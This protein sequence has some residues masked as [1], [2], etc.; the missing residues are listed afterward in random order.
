M[1][2]AEIMLWVLPASVALMVTPAI[3]VRQLIAAPTPV[4]M[5][6]S[7]SSSRR[8]VLASSLTAVLAPL[9][10]SAG[11]AEDESELLTE[12]RKIKSI[13]DAIRNEQKLELEERARIKSATQDYEQAA[14][15]G[16][17][18]KAAGLKGKV[19]ALQAQLDEEV[20]QVAHE[21]Q[22]GA[23]ASCSRRVS[24]M[25]Q[26]KVLARLQEEEKALVDTE[27]KQ[28]AKVQLEQ[29]SELARE[30]KE[31]SEASM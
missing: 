25:L 5:S 21:P 28:F 12:D 3:S 2:I 18:E 9:V 14:D 29:R 11:L 17:S 22:A 19:A 6:V 31:A 7:G 15:A 8:S 13:D 20:C 26:D 24:P 1:P 30:D 27:K 16:D 4:Q 23:L 10:A